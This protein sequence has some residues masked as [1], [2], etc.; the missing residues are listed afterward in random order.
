M[1]DVE[2]IWIPFNPEKANNPAYVFKTRLKQKEFVGIVKY[3]TQEWI[4]HLQKLPNKEKS[5]LAK[6][7][8]A[9][10][11]AQKNRAVTN[12]LQPHARTVESDGY[13]EERTQWRINLM[14][15]ME[16]DGLSENEMCLLASIVDMEK[17]PW[18]YAQ[19]LTADLPLAQWLSLE[20]INGLIAADKLNFR[21]HAVLLTEPNQ[22]EKTAL[23]AL[24]PLILTNQLTVQK[25]LRTR[26]SVEALQLLLA[27]DFIARAKSSTLNHDDLA[28]LFSINLSLN[29]IDSPDDSHANAE[30]EDWYESPH[31]SQSDESGNENDH[32]S[33]SSSSESDIDEDPD[34][35]YLGAKPKRR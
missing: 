34:I 18:G 5:A 9:L 32:S 31:S 1:S 33:S 13:V 23:H 19:L 6:E 30:Y 28:L 26:I 2:D 12:Y 29:E 3:K 25:A 7:H 16:G 21:D 27:P 15:P 17:Y 14:F 24:A 35:Q 11:E 22:R 4:D 10:I 20:S 8:R